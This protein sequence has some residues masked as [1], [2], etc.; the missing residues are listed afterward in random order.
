MP[1][2]VRPLLAAVAIGGLAANAQAALITYTN[3][4]DFLAAIETAYYQESFPTLPLDV[5]T[6]PRAFAAVNGYA[7]SASA[8]ANLYG[9]NDQGTT[10]NRALSTNSSVDAIT[11]TF[12]GNAV[13]AVGGWFY[14]TN[15]NGSALTGRIDLTF[16]SGDSWFTTTASIGSFV[17]FVTSTPITS[18]IIE[19]PEQACGTGECYATLDD[20]IL[21]TP[22]PEDAPAP[23]TIA[24]LGLGLF[25]IGL[26]RRSRS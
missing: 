18:L 8:P 9:L 6:S 14:P 16:S 24:L 20:L 26:G 12:S 15:I 7:F 3:Q 10:G 25:G 23:A 5:V 1:S 21:G 2:P 11:L 22:K 4:A 17:G 13:S 19:A